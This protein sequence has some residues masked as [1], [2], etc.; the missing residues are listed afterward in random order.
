MKNS[1]TKTF[2]ILLILGVLGLVSACVKPTESYLDFYEKI[3]G[4]TYE[5]RNLPEGYGE[6]TVEIERWEKYI[7]FTFRLQFASL[8]VTLYQDPDEPIY[9]W[10][11]EYYDRIEKISSLEYS[12]ST[13][14]SNI[15]Y[16]IVES[17]H[18]DPSSETY[19]AVSSTAKQIYED[20]LP[21]LNDVISQISGGAY[22]SIDHLRV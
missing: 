17:E 11:R 20:L 4:A 5:A 8:K 15:S 1:L 16:V 22:T 9:V 2:S 12:T 14:M 21:V 7:D 18:V 19:A 6:V 13:V 3:D 10:Y